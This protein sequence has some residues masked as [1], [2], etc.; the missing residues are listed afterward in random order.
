MLVADDSPT[1]QKKASGIL[2]GEGLDVVTVSNGVA[3]IKKLLTIK[4]QLVLAD[5]S[6]PGRDGYEVCEFIKSSPDLHHVAVLLVVGADEPY[7]EKRSA[8]VHADGKIQKPFDRDELISTVTKYLDQVDGSR[9]ATPEGKG[10]EPAVVAVPMDEG[11]E[12]PWKRGLDL[13]SL[14]EEVPFAEPMFEETPEITPE[15]APPAV[16]PWTGA[17][18][19]GPATASP[20]EA[21]PSPP[22][23]VFLEEPPAVTSAP[24]APETDRTVR[25]RLPSDLAEPFMRDEL[26]PEPPPETGET[27]GARDVLAALETFT[28]PAANAEQAQSVPSQTEAPPDAIAA[29]PGP[30]R[31]AFVAAA[32]VARLDADLIHTIIQKVVAKMSPPA[33]PS[34]IVNDLA[35]KF[36]DEIIGEIDSEPS[37]SH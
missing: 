4:P 29:P 26:A 35:K 7:D 20:V 5:V 16:E 34:N 31:E 33:L 23:P 9:A 3:A 8:S 14:P 10:A 6:M 36:A 32:P 12:A 11:F 27:G 15:P 21:S 25:F 19:Q 17:P 13:A 24:P 30:A 2:T 22:E 18:E 1:I 28:L 37:E